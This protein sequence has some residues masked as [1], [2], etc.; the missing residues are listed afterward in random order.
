M[1]FM[2]VKAYY[3]TINTLMNVYI[4]STLKVIW[5]SYP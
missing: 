4:R 5:F 3:T 2:F 1:I